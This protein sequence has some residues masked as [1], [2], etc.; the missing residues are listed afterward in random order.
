MTALRLELAKEDA[1]RAHELP[2]ETSPSVVIQLGVDIEDQQ[3][4]CFLSAFE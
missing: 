3:C 4:E 2:S 1:A